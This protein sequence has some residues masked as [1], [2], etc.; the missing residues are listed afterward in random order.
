M[1]FVFHEIHVHTEFQSAAIE[2]LPSVWPRAMLIYWS[3]GKLFLTPTGYDWLR[4]QL[5]TMTNVAVVTSC[6]NT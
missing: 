3:T 1:F 4:H 5:G 6:E 2:P